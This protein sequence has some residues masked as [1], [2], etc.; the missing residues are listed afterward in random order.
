MKQGPP[1][2]QHYVPQ[3]LL[4]QFA[5][6]DAKLWAYDAENRRM[7]ASNPKGLAAEGFFYGGTT[8]HATRESTA[9]ESW[10]AQEIERPGADAIAQLLARRQLS[11]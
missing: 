8:K 5:G 6:A 3:L 9:I 11:I 2:L 10:L 4:R 7:F 1:R